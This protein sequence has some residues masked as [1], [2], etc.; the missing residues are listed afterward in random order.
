MP[1]SSRYAILLLC[2]VCA[3]ALGASLRNELVWD[4]KR[5]VLNSPATAT[6]TRAVASFVPAR[7]RTTTQ[8]VQ[9]SYRP[10]ANVSLAVDNALW[11]G[12]PAGYHLSNLLLHIVAVIGLFWLGHAVLRDFRVPWPG[13][14]AMFAALVFAVH[15][16]LVEATVW[17]ENRGVVLCTI[18]CLLVYWNLLAFW[19]GR[20]GPVGYVGALIAFAAAVTTQEAA[21]AL[22]LTLVLHALLRPEQAGRRRRL[23]QTL[24]FFVIAAAFALLRVSALRSGVLMVHDT[25]DI[26]VTHR[27]LAVV[28]TLGG[29]LAGLVLPLRLCSDRYFIIPRSLHYHGMM[30]STLALAAWVGFFAV[31]T[32]LWRLVVFGL[33]SVL[34]ALLPVANIVFIPGRPMADQRLYLPALGLCLVAGG[35]LAH[36]RQYRRHVAC[37]LLAAIV[38]V[39]AGM[40]TRRVFDFQSD[41][42]FWR[43]AACASPS[44]GRTLMNLGV[45]CQREFYVSRA[46]K[47]F[48]SVVRKYPGRGAAHHHLGQV[49]LL[50]GRFADALGPLETACGLEAPSPQT[51]VDAASA[52][53]A[54]KR[55]D[56]AIARIESAKVMARA[57]SEA[58]YLASRILRV[59]GHTAEADAELREAK[60][61]L[62]LEQDAL[63]EEPPR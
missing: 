43:S 25:P 3:F 9:E 41:Y 38:C 52:L 45:Q 32:R 15:P 48:R 42:A 22:P 28:R 59:R 1:H 16:A 23:A 58:W 35:V 10:V 14:G 30:S 18:L 20:M 60:R 11:R 21:V 47:L 7:W 33:G 49:L 27:A 56:E 29:Y 26:P 57:P 13:V 5:L 63:S 44:K 2:F 46:E 19:N 34:V 62:T 37:G 51:L 53:Y 6:L 24:P 12:V 31:P 17:T 50:Q 39:F 61:R 55:Y 40:A 8:S 54:L 4:T 36:S